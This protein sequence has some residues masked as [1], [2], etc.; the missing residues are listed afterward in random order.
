M[1]DEKECFSDISILIIGFDGYVDVWNHCFE[2]MN[3]YW[4]IR[5]KTYLAC[6]ELKPKYENVEV[7]NAGK[8][9]EWSKKV[10]ISLEHINTKYVLLMLED[11]FIC[12]YVDNAQILKIMQ[13][14]KENKI[15]FYQLLVQLIHQ[16]AI[17]GKSYKNYRH[18]RIVAKDK[19]YPL[20]LQA[21][22]WEKDYLKERVGIG[23]YN[24]WMFEIHQ[25]HF[26]EYNTKHIDC[27]I[28]D[29]NICNIVHAVV[30]SKYL[31][32][33]IR[34]LNACGYHINKSEREILNKRENFEYVLK[35]FMYE[36]T[37]Q[38]LVKPA[39]IIAKLIK[40]DFVTD[41]I[42]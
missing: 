10:Q 19:K 23:N 15:K 4:P 38:F 24:A 22:I 9:S 16:K 12:D 42:K 11:F 5:P 36:V 31:P 14:I 34:K 13:L 32:S 1:Q 7:I 2:L 27:L 39:K 28:D 35:L 6:S 17:K 40:V 37:P 3:K 25:L 18:I 30:Q 20:N 8:N 21:A 41:R 33:A 26:K 29:R